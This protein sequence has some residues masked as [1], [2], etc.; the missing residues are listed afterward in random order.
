ML[1]PARP[2]ASPISA[3][4]PGRFSSAIVRSFMLHCHTSSAAASQGSC[5]A[6]FTRASWRCSAARGRPGRGAGRGPNHRQHDSA[7][8]RA[9]PGAPANGRG[10]EPRHRR[11][12][13]DLA[14]EREARLHRRGRRDAA[15]TR[16][17]AGPGRSAASQNLA[18][19]PELGLLVLDPQT[20]QPHALQRPRPR[21]AG[22]LVPASRTRSTATA[23]STSSFA[24][25]EAEARADPGATRVPDRLDARQQSLIASADT[26]FIGSVHPQGAPTP[27]IAAASRDS[28]ACW[29]PIGSRFADYPGNTM[30]NTLGNLSRTRGPGLLFVDFATGDVLQLT[31]RASIAPDFTV[32]FDIEAVLRDA[33]AAVRCVGSSSSTRRP[34]QSC[35]TAPRPAS[36]GTRPARRRRRRVR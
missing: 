32:V 9:L 33:R 12:R 1:T 36:Q 2:R 34:T 15:A 7:G 3:S 27:R 35:H 17:T 28:C 11:P 8:G 18:A 10:C 21:F 16:G 30:F 14:A 13:L 31:G 26:F 6:L 24:G 29:R 5:T 4:A 23:R 22:G 25:P 20:R 19:R